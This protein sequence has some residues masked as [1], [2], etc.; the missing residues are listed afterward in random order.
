[1]RA[2]TFS[3]VAVQGDP[4]ADLVVRRSKKKFRSAKIFL[5]FNFIGVAS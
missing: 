5:L 4:D 3:A 1:M 2:Q